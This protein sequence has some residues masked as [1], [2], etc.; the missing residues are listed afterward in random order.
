MKY[1]FL[2]HK[3][4]F[5][6]KVFGRTK[7]ELFLSAVAGMS[8]VLGPEGKGKA[9]A[10]KVKVTSQDSNALLADFLNE[11]NYLIQT[12]REFYFN[13][14]FNKLTNTELQATLFG[15]KVKEFREEI[16]AV[17]HHGLQI[18]QNKT[19]ALETAIIFDI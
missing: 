9:V 2:E 8:A 6:I 4:D 1:E 15:N 16:K 13:V 14:K 17:T 5:K 10:R 12:K 3:G 11:V 7:E 19:G 18:K